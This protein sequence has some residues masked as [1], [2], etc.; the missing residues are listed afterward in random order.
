MNTLTLD[1]LIEF[2]NES[3]GYDDPIEAGP[4]VIDS[5]FDALGC[6][7]LTLLNAISKIERTYQT[8]LPESVTSD[9]KTPRELIDLVNARLS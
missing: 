6:D 2:L 3:N 4:E 5:P 7:S 9:A 8:E 1:A